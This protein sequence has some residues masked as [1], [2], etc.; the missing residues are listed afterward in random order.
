MQITG[1][2]PSIWEAKDLHG[3][4]CVTGRGVSDSLSLKVAEEETPGYQ[5]V[6]VVLLQEGFQIEVTV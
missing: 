5:Q 3:V 2:M 6:P 1:N 4:E